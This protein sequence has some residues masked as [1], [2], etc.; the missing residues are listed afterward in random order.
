MYSASHVRRFYEHAILEHLSEQI[1]RLRDT[2]MSL[3]LL[4]TR[5]L[6][7]NNK[8]LNGRAKTFPGGGKVSK[9]S[10]GNDP[11][12]LLLRHLFNH[13]WLKRREVWEEIGS[14]GIAEE[15]GIL[16]RHQEAD[17]PNDVEDMDVEEAG[18]MH[19]NMYE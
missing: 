5:Y 14:E 16:D 7:A 19:S 18:K 10:Y 2:G 13:N 9:R 15:Q 1:T 11:K 3:A 6:E 17:R 12:F 8:V 4:Q